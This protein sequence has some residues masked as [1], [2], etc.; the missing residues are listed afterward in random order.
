MLRRAA[1]FGR[2]FAAIA[3]AKRPTAKPAPVALPPRPRGWQKKGESRPPPQPKRLEL[4]LR[5]TLEANL[6]VLPHACAVGDS[7]G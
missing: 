1:T 7:K 2:S 4:R 6:A 3:T 5:G